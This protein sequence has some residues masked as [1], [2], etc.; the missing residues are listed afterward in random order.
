[1]KIAWTKE[2]ILWL[3]PNQEGIRLDTGE[4][5]KLSPSPWWQKPRLISCYDTLPPP[6]NGNICFLQREQ[7]KVFVSIGGEWILLTN[8]RII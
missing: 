4:W 5:I 3:V 8:W 1:M 2:D 6:S 7:D